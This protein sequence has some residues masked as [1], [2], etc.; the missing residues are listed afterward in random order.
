M[1][2][3][4]IPMITRDE[5]NDLLIEY[6]DDPVSA[7][8]RLL[9]QRKAAAALRESEKDRRDSVRSRHRHKGLLSLAFLPISGYNLQDSDRAGI[10]GRRISRIS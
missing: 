8:K 4:D 10:H 5:S 3:G 2:S 7:L 9:E 1:A 6:A